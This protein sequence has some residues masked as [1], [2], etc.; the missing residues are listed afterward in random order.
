ML[1]GDLI[2]SLDCDAAATDMLL[3]GGDLALLA[4]VRNAASDAGVPL[5][6]CLEDLIGH[7]NAAATADDW[8][9]VM[10]AAGRSET[11]GAACLR[12]MLDVAL[13]TVE[14]GDRTALSDAPHVHARNA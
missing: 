6:D 1:L 11:P 4:R 5:V 13:A 7:F 3:A 12:V 8:I 10:N 2:A 9:A 14:S